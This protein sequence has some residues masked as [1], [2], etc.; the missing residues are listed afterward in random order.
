VKDLFST[1]FTKSIL[2]LF[3][4]FCAPYSLAND[5]DSPNNRLI[6]GARYN[7]F[8]DVISALNQKADIN[9]KD[10]NGMTPLMWAAYHGRRSVLNLFLRKGADINAQDKDG[11]TPLM[12]SVCC[13]QYDLMEPILKAGANVNVKDKDGLT[14]LMY[15][16]MNYAWDRNFDRNKYKNGMTPLMYTAWKCALDRNSY[17]WYKNKL[18]KDLLNAG[19]DMNAEDKNGKTAID[20]AN[21]SEDDDNTANLPQTISDHTRSSDD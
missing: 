17:A 7:V 3:L 11:M 5:Y 20:Y 13:Y 9:A 16:A 1:L 8:E 15:A 6:Y 12:H 2:F 18:V 21:Y 4:F 19:A 14:P 10:E